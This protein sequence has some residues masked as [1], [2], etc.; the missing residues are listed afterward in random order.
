MPSHGLPAVKPPL[1]ESVV[2]AKGALS[3]P[4]KTTATAAKSALTVEGPPGS[5]SILAG[6]VAEPADLHAV[7]VAVAAPPVESD[8][9][10]AGLRAFAANFLA[11]YRRDSV[12]P[13][14]SGL[15]RLF[16]RR[17]TPPSRRPPRLLPWRSNPCVALSQRSSCRSRT[18]HP[19][20][21][22]PQGPAPVPSTRKS[23]LAEDLFADVMALT[24]EERIAL[25]T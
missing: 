13:L 24:G 18:R 1:V 11:E 3:L 10:T 5:F 16:Q 7:T 19:L 23:D 8:P 9:L 17:L 6:R 25:F 12:V 2:D 15:P 21:D 4:A 20:G 14:A 22:L